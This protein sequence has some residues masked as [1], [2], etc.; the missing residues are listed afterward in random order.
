[1][2]LPISMKR[3][4]ARM[5][6][7]SIIGN[8]ISW[9]YHD[10]IPSRGNIIV[11]NNCKIVPSIKASLFWGLYESTEI[12]F[13]QQYLRCDLDVIEL[14]AS[15]GVVSTHIARKLNP[16]NRLICIEANA[17]LLEQININVATNNKQTDLVIVHGAL[18]YSDNNNAF[19]GFQIGSQNI[20]SKISQ[21]ETSVDVVQVPT[22]TLRNVLA[23]QAI[24]SFAL[25]SDIEGAEVSLF[26]NEK[27]A[28]EQCQQMIIELHDFVYEGYM[29]QTA[30]ICDIIQIKHGFVLRDR[31]GNVCVFDKQ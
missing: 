27:E 23:E 4:I 12:G 18:H 10:R 26:L 29:Y 9:A 6:C 15:I 25:V 17:H 11:T 28:L 8:L 16:A 19:V 2:R 5:M 20:D 22:T 31:R 30:E 1:M 13:I 14:G 7:H 21:S 24:T 3:K